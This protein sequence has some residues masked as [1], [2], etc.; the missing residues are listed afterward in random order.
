M[1]FHVG[2]AFL[3]DDN[4]ASPPQF[5][6]RIINGNVAKPNTTPWMAALHDYTGFV[7]GGTLI[8][9]R[10]VLTAKHCIEKRN[11][12]TVLLGVYDR[13]CPFWIFSGV[14]L[15][16]PFKFVPF[17]GDIALIKLDRK[18]V[19]NA[20]IRPICIII[21]Q[22]P[23]TWL[24]TQRFEAYGWGR[25]E[26]GLTSQVLKTVSLNRVQCPAGQDPNGLIC[27]W[28][29]NGDT[30]NGDSG[31]PLAAKIIYKGKSIYAQF[32]IVSSGS[33]N[34]DNIGIYTDIMSYN[35]LLFI[36]HALDII[37]LHEK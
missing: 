18:V 22:E 26:T 20:Q 35:S 9:E 17:S 7:C 2:L 29:W 27:A 4:C 3:L 14:E 21:E 30:C 10:N 37:L 24:P 12:T 15:Y 8:T 19:Y 13:R 1:I 36:H 31:G 23:I 11:I 5:E 16:R 28:S 32:G 6:D 33:P 25:T 34:C